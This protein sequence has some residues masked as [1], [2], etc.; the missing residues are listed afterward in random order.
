MARH[1]YTDHLKNVTLFS[2]LTNKELDRVAQIATQ[3]D[4]APGRVLMREGESAH[5]MFVVI[6]GTLDVTK[7]G[8]HIADLGPGSFAGEMALLTHSHRSATV[9]AKTDVS[10]LHIDG[11]GFTAVLRDVPQIAVKMLPVVA[12]RVVASSDNHEH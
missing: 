8:E 7:D 3:L 9:S 2:E 12:A 1:A 4:Y 5:E 11:R 10:V 6:E